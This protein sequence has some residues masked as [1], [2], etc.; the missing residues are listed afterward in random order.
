MGRLGKNNLDEPQ[1]SKGNMVFD[2][3][4]KTL[5]TWR[6]I[7]TGSH[8]DTRTDEELKNGRPHPK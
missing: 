4:E 8:G 7:Q 5:Q 3:V 1:I 2:V 6:K